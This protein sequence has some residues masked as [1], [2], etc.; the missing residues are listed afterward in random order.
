MKLQKETDWG[1]GREGVW[2]WEKEDPEARDAKERSWWAIPM[3]ELERGRKLC[4]EVKLGA[5]LV[6]FK[7]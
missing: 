3:N 2:L 4:L 6:I 5:E 1:G 7:L